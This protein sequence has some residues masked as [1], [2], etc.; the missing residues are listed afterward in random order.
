MQDHTVRTFDFM[1]HSLGTP[2][3]T[4][5][6]TQSARLKRLILLLYEKQTQNERDQLEGYISR[7]GKRRWWLRLGW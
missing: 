6:R 1:I 3:D 4:L 7:I 5:S 2:W